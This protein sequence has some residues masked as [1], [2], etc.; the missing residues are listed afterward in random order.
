V[1]VVRPFYAAVAADDK[2]AVLEVFRLFLPGGL[3]AGLCHA[4]LKPSPPPEEQ[5]VL[6]YVTNGSVAKVF[7]P[8]S[9]SRVFPATQVHGNNEKLPATWPATFRIFRHE[10]FAENRL[11]SFITQ[12]NTT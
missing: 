5:G 7:P 4:F 9:L 1:G 10:S 8:A 3:I 12:N 11:I 6:C 2:R